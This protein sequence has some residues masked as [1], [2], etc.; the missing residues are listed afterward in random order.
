MHLLVQT[1]DK[2]AINLHLGPSN[3]LDGALQ[4]LAAGQTITF[5]AF[6]TKRLP[7]DAYIAKRVTTIEKTLTLRDDTL[8][9]VWAVGQGG[10]QGA[11][12]GQGQGQGRG[13]APG[14][15]GW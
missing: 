8:R 11:G 13:K 15:C 2:R 3:A 7:K 10:G 6:R 9:P 1:L 12:Q 4:R 14:A 5:D